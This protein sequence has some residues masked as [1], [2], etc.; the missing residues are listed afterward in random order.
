MG[1]NIT[2][3][4][5]ESAGMTQHCDFDLE[6][7]LAS[8]AGGGRVD[9]VAKYLKESIPIDAK[10]PLAAYWDALDIEDPSLRS[11]KMQ[12]HAQQVKATS[13]HWLREITLEF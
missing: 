6:Y 7:T 12:E 10:V 13:K 8:G 2:K 5:A 11:K 4:V 1:R 9:M 3:N